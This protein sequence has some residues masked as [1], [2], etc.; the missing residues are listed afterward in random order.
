VYADPIKYEILKILPERK[1]GIYRKMTQEL[2][3]TKCEFKKN[4]KSVL[5]GVVNVSLG[6]N[7]I[8]EVPKSIDSTTL[9]VVDP[10]SSLII[11]KKIYREFED[12]IL[13]STPT[14][15]LITSDVD[16]KIT[17]HG[18]LV[19]KNMD[20]A[21]VIIYEPAV[22]TEGSERKVTVKE[23]A[24][25]YEITYLEY[26]NVETVD[27]NVAQGNR[28]CIPFKPRI[29][30][31]FESNSS[32]SPVALSSMT[33][34]V[35]AKGMVSSYS[36]QVELAMSATGFNWGAAYRM[37]LD[38]QRNIISVFE[39]D[40]WCENKTD[41]N[42]KNVEASFLSRS[43]EGYIIPRS[44]SAQ[45]LV[46]SAK[47]SA[48]ST[49]SVIYTLK[50]RIDVAARSITSQNF[51]RISSIHMLTNL[52]L[53]VAENPSHPNTLISFICPLE[54]ENGI[55]SGDVEIWED[56][57]VISNSYIDTTPPKDTVILDLGQNTFV[58]VKIDHATEPIRVINPKDS[59]T[60]M[61]FR[62]L[63]DSIEQMSTRHIVSVTIK[64]LWD[65]SVT[66]IPYHPVSKQVN[67]VQ[68]N[69]NVSYTGDIN[70]NLR[71]EFTLPL[72]YP[73]QEIKLAYSFT[74]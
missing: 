23:I 49:G 41:L 66:V 55:P 11:T 26:D 60:A 40:L 65:K 42:L 20:F 2:K 6:W 29:S 21:T 18:I 27:N 45:S 35:V 3:Y 30:L 56:G 47:S 38:F 69:Y 19:K 64:N 72:I 44:L 33:S 4:G 51:F 74:E 67:D 50:D 17:L 46:R 25:P 28:K 37:Y 9:S 53:D 10:K 48:T 5:R 1:R 43:D 16:K 57:K 13:P 73:G 54:L 32:P 59:K 14:E 71:L 52:M 36:S 31:Y 58:K 22:A 62:S 39:S 61:S 15:V 34:G 68:S 24:P 7:L 63:S 8:E 70:T 12:S